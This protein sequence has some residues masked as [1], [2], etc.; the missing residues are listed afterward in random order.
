M[1][2]RWLSRWGALVLLL[3]TAI[4]PLQVSVAQDGG[5]DQVEQDGANLGGVGEVA[6][7]ADNLNVSAVPT[8]EQAQSAVD[9]PLNADTQAYFDNAGGVGAAVNNLGVEA[10]ASRKAQHTP[11]RQ[12]NEVIY[13]RTNDKGEVLSVYADYSLVVSDSEGE[14]FHGYVTLDAAERL[15]VVGS[16]INGNQYAI[17]ADSG[18]RIGLTADG[19]VLMGTNDFWYIY[20]Y[21]EDGNFLG[22]TDSEEN[23]YDVAVDDDGNYYITDADGNTGEFYADGSYDVYDEEGTVFDEGALF[24]DNDNDLEMGFDEGD[25]AASFD[26]NSEEESFESDEEAPESSLDEN[27]DDQSSSEGGAAGVSDETLDESGG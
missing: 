17:Y 26:E 9:T 7:A 4:S 14:Y 10:S 22:M 16:A 24:G 6:K 2:T 23:E 21:D 12:A 11:I 5:E 18:Y 20:D 15:M 3:L 19:D 27:T 8:Q 25:D 13:E 1:D